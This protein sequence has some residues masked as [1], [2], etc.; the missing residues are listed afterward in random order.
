L[1]NLALSRLSP[2]ESGYIGVYSC[3]GKDLDSTPSA[4]VDYAE[5]LPSLFE[6]EVRD[7]FVR[8]RQ[9]LVVVLGRHFIF[10]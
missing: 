5:V 2:E 9:E 1:N 3:A 8:T 10:N 4:G 7:R 6:L